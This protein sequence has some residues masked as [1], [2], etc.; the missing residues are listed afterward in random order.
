MSFDINSVQLV[1]RAGDELTIRDMPNGRRIASF[2]MVTN[3]TWIEKDTGVKKED[4]TWHNIF[5][6]SDFLI[7]DLQESGFKKGCNVMVIGELA[8]DSWEDATG[9]KRYINKVV[10][11]GVSAA[12]RV[13]VK[14]APPQYK[15]HESKSNFDDLPPF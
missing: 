2:R 9:T 10:V 12:V 7:T 13:L 5:I 8:V 3:R 14:P 11:R 15:S 1:G 4:S 6:G